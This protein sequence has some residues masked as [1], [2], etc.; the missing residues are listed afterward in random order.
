LSLPDEKVSM[1]T[2]QQFRRPLPVEGTGTFFYLGDGKGSFIYSTA[3]LP[4]E[5]KSSRWD[6]QV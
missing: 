5:I 1:A 6:Y 3:G 4:L 2:R